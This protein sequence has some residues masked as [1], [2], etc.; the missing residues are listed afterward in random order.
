[1]VH[2]L[3]HKL[4]HLLELARKAIDQVLLLCSHLVRRQ[5]P[6]ILDLLLQLL[7]QLVEEG[8]RVTHLFGEVLLV[9]PDVPEDLH[10]ELGEI[11]LK[12]HKVGLNLLKIIL[13]RLEVH[14]LLLAD[15]LPKGNLLERVQELLAEGDVLL[16]LLSFVVRASVSLH[17]VHQLDVHFEFVVANFEIFDLLFK[18]SNLF[19]CVILPPPERA[20]LE[21][22]IEEPLVAGR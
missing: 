6:H 19:I 17:L 21:S 16:V 5:I 2:R 20:V 22:L 18:K 3:G 12:A 8:I 13:M 1:M 14:L 15:L 4:V 7:G 10:A 9:S 11:V